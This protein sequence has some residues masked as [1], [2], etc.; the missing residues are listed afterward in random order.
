[1]KQKR[2][3]KR[4]HSHDERFLVE[5]SLQQKD[6]LYEAAYKATCGS[7]LRS[8]LLPT[9]IKA[10]EDVLGISYDAWYNKKL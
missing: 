3:K 10:A 2:A 7:S 9:I 1:M 6:F 4:G 8:W 5:C